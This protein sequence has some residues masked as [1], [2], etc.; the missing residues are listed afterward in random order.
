LTAVIFSSYTANGFWVR[1]SKSRCSGNS[2]TISII[3]G[4]I[5]MVQRTKLELSKEQRLG[6]FLMLWDTKDTNRPA[7]GAVKRLA[8][9]SDV[10]RST[11]DRLWRATKI[12][13]DSCLIVQNGTPLDDHAINAIIRDIGFY[14]SGRKLSGAKLKWDRKELQE[15]V[16][17]KQACWDASV[18]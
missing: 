8:I 7:R 11:I 2:W 1:T 18:A 17:A 10:D 13:L 3:F 6:V 16:Q 12:K 5:K 14:E 9:H 15:V 4:P